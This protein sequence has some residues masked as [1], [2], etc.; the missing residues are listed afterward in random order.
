VIFDLSREA[1]GSRPTQLAQTL[2]GL[3]AADPGAGRLW[4][5]FGEPIQAGVVLSRGQHGAGAPALVVTEGETVFT[6]DQDRHVF[7]A[8]GATL[9][10]V[11]PADA[12]AWRSLTSA[13]MFVGNL[14]VLDAESGQLWKHEPPARGTGAFGPALGFLSAALPANTARSVAVDG[15]VWV[16]TTAGE[17]LRFR[18]QGFSATAGR[19]DF[20]VRWQGEPVRATAIQAID[21]QR[22][23]YLLDAP[24]RVIV[25]LSRDG[26]EI[27]RF[28]LASALAEA[29]AFFVS[30]GQSLAYTVHGAK[31]AQTDITR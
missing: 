14:Y 5:I 17:V 23:I 19:I 21:S 4:R 13:T 31:I 16:V 30:E 29:S 9:I 20:T 7:R 25:Q 18:R 26:R 10:V 2:N 12:A 15:D 22:F 28:P 3:Y 8:E 11:T 6:I 27:G 24:G 1:A